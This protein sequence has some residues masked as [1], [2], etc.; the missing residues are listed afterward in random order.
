[1]WYSGSAKRNVEGRFRLTVIADT[2]LSPFKFLGIDALSV[3]TVKRLHHSL[4]SNGTHGE[5]V[6]HFRLSPRQ[7]GR[8]M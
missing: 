5:G 7:I 1:M 3:K 2:D 6:L 8:V 4:G